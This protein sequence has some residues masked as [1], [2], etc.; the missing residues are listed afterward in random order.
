MDTGLP[1]FNRWFPK[2]K[3]TGY[4]VTSERTARYNCFSWVLGI[5]DRK[6]SPEASPHYFWPEGVP[7]GYSLEDFIAAYAVFGFSVCGLDD[8]F[9]KGFEKIA[10]YGFENQPKHAAHQKEADTWTSKIGDFED[11]EHTLA[12]LSGN[13]YYGEVLV[14]LKRPQLP[15]PLP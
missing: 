3:K 9:E 15:P 5:T 11:I 8:T 2:L 13:E 12:G 1:S 14:I 10:L 6:M 4:S 7:R